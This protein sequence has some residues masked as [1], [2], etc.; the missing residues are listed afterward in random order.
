MKHAVDPATTFLTRKK[1][2][3]LLDMSPQHL[4]NLASAKRGPRFSKLGDDQQ[5]HTRYMLADVIAYGTDPKA[6]EAAVWGRRANNARRQKAG[7]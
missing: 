4:A 2:A 6:H 3:Q 1:A 7:R 5:S